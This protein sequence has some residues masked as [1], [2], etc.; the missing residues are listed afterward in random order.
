MSKTSV[1]IHQA[2]PES[3]P[4]KPDVARNLALGAVVALMFSLGIAFYMEYLDAST[5]YA[6]GKQKQRR[7]AKPQLVTADIAESCEM[8]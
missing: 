5:P 2:E 3:R 6:V 7:S 4:C 8:F 1:T